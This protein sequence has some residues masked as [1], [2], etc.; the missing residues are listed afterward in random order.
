MGVGDTVAW[1]V[2]GDGVDSGVAVSRIGGVAVG[3]A[4]SPGVGV[5]AGTGMVTGEVAVGVGVPGCLAVGVAMGVARGRGVLTSWVVGVGPRDLSGIGVGVAAAP[6]G[7]S[8]D[9][10]GVARG[11][12][13]TSGTGASTRSVGVG[14]WPLQA[15][16]RARSRGRA[17]PMARMVQSGA[18]PSVILSR[19][20]R[21]LRRTIPRTRPPCRPSGPTSAGAGSDGVLQIT[22]VR[23]PP[24][25]R[26][27]LRLPLPPMRGQGT[28][29][30]RVW[31]P[32]SA[33]VGAGIQ[34]AALRSARPRPRAAICRSTTVLRWLEA[35]AMATGQG[36]WP[37]PEW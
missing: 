2:V 10:T 3:V 9:A 15:M 28:A 16:T 7:G 11:R 21:L 33:G 6:P 31:R 26:S 24:R 35:M 20:G 37:V 12:T 17:M 5:A 34:A 4:M 29:G 19:K 27:R 25:L 23:T 30:T 32:R 13:E 36:R 1:A 22:S 8:R 14:S 18:A